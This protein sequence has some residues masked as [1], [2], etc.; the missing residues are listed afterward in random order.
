MDSNSNTKNKSD[1]SCTK[2]ISLSSN[3]IISALRSKLNFLKSYIFKVRGEN[4][5][6]V[7]IDCCSIAI[8][9]KGFTDNTTLSV[10]F[11]VLE[12]WLSYYTQ[13][14]LT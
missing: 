11:L 12:I 7:L 10:G 2:H 8:G 4:H 13:E 1:G 3:G 6:D 14:P 5:S 9:D